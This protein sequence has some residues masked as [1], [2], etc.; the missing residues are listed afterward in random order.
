MNF[1]KTIL[2]AT[3]IGVILLLYAVMIPFFMR[4]TLLF[5]PLITIIA[6]GLSWR[7]WRSRFIL[8]A[9]LVLLLHVMF[10]LA[11]VDI[12]FR[13]TGT[14]GIRMVPFVYGLQTKEGMEKIRRGEFIYGGCFVP[15]HPPRYA[16]VFSF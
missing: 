16:A 4:N 6:L 8:T 13:K 10:I 15:F 7:Y 3:V 11:P 5:A 1:K 14:A 2:T 12:R 9:V